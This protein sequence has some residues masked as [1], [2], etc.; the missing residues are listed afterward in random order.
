MSQRERNGSKNSGQKEWAVGARVLA[1]IVMIV[2]VVLFYPASEPPVVI[3]KI[4]DTEEGGAERWYT[5]E[6]VVQGEKLFAQNCAA[7]HGKNAEATSEWRKT[8]D[9]GNYPPPP[10]NGT[11]HA[12][13]HPL[14]VLRETIQQGGVPLGGVMPGFSDKLSVQETDTVIAW[15]QSLWPDELYQAWYRMEKESQ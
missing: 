13:H 10:L 11:A 1:A 3:P 2:L 9:S 6:Q 4:I 7:C 15:F 5:A 8:D 14:S 12:W